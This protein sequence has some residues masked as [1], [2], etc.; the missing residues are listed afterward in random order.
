MH[1][2]GSNKKERIH[3]TLN[4]F[5][6][7]GIVI[8]I[9]RVLCSYAFDINPEAKPI[10]DAGWIS[11]TLILIWIVAVY[12]HIIR[13]A[14]DTSLSVGIAICFGYVI[15]NTIVLVTFAKVLGIS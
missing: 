15:V 7:A 4:A 3:Q 10:S 9:V 13:H 5:L 8:G 11:L 2:I 6:G 14:V 12:G 1:S